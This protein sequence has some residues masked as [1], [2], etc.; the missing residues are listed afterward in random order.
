MALVHNGK[1]PVDDGFLGG[2]RSDLEAGL[3]ILVGIHEEF[4]DG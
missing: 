3:A 1:H 4:P 2:E